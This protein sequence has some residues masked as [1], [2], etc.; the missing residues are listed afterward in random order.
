M[1]D[2]FSIAVA[3]HI[4]DRSTRMHADCKAAIAQALL[5]EH[6]Q[7]RASKVFAGVSAFAR[8]LS[9]HGHVRSTQRVTAHRSEGEIDS[10]PPG[11]RAHAKGNR[12]AD[13]HAEEAHKLHAP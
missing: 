1:A 4:A 6:E 13:L 3:C 7:L 9:G 5:P 11:E 12:A 10:L 8:S 2:T